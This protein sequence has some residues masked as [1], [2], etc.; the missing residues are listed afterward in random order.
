MF[1][2]CVIHLIVE[3]VFPETVPIRNY[4]GVSP[5]YLKDTTDIIIQLV[6][7]CKITKGN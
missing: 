7:S 5:A 2:Y 4:P 6:F 3:Y 1:S